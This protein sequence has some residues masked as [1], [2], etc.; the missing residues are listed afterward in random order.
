MQSFTHI[1][2]RTE[3]SNNPSHRAVPKPYLT[4][5]ETEAQRGQD[6]CARAPGI[7]QMGVGISAL[8]FPGCV[9][10]GKKEKGLCPSGPPC[11]QQ[12]YL[13]RHWRGRDV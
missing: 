12:E 8:P 5:R 13:M 10:L 4:D 1:P 11:V 3:L 2:I 9:S 7:R 6:T